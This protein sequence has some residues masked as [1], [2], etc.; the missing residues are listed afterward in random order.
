MIRYSPVAGKVAFISLGRALRSILTKRTPDI[1]SFSIRVARLPVCDPDGSLSSLM[2]PVD[3]RVRLRG[4]SL[5][6]PQGRLAWNT[7]EGNVKSL[8]L[9]QVAGCPAIKFRSHAARTPADAGEVGAGVVFTPAADAGTLG[10]GPVG[11]TAAHGAVWAGNSVVVPCDQ[12]PP[13]AES[14]ARADNQ[15]V[16]AFTILCIE[17]IRRLVVPDDQVAETGQ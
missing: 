5:P 1:S 10:G 8:C 4:I 11:R 15:I 2:L 12:P 13:T 17:V 14:V 6:L 3:D 16:G 9:V 7:S